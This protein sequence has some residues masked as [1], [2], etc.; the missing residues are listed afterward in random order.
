MR[1]YYDEITR[2]AG[3]VATVR[4]RGVGYD[5]LAV[6]YTSF[7]PSLAQ[8]IRLEEDEVSFQIFAG[9]EGVS[10]GDRV[11]FLGRPMQVPFAS[12]LLG[13]VFDG[14]CRPRDNRPEIREGMIEIGSPAVNPVK[15]RRP[16]RMIHTGIPMIDAGNP[17]MI[18]FPVWDSR[19][20]P[21]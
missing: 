10:T 15:R 2:I 5:E 1:K 19:R 6:I 14:S 3:N 16:D 7:G 18:S 13:R 21:M 12:S 9:T 8:V 20:M 11:R 4:A 17:T